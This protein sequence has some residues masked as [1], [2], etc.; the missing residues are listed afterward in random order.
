MKPLACSARAVLILLSALCLAA[1]R[2]VLAQGYVVT[3]LQTLGGNY[4][5]ARG[6]NASGWVVGQAAT[7]NG[8]GRPFLW[9]PQRQ[10]GT[11]GTMMDLGTLGGSFGTAWGIN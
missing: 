7:R 8:G 9:I 5:Y 6:I 4:S 2:P 1:P 11:I 10:N 3:D